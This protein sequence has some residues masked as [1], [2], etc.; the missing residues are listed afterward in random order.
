MYFFTM[1]LNNSIWY[2]ITFLSLI[3]YFIFRFGMISKGAKK[4]LIEFVGGVGILTSFFLMLGLFGFISML[5]LIPIFF[6]INTLI[7]EAIIQFINKK[8][9]GHY[10]KEEKELAK[11]MGIPIDQLRK[12]MNMNDKKIFET[13][14]QTSPD[15]FDPNFSQNA[16]NWIKQYSKSKDDGLLKNNNQQAGTGDAL[17]KEVVNAIK[18]KTHFPILSTWGQGILVETIRSMVEKGYDNKPSA[19]GSAMIMLEMDLQHERAANE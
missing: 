4:G 10:I 9:Y 6:L 1:Q 7:V 18:D 19:V 16:K 12:Y 3:S 17:E 5:I 2:L 11:R 15:L 13:L 14:K 8:L